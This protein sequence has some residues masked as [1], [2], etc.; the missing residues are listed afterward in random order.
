[1]PEPTESKAV[2]RSCRW[3]RRLLAVYPKA[4]RQEYGAAILQLFRDQ[5]R[6]AWAERRLR[7]LIA[8]WLR[9]LFDLLKTS[10]A[11]HFSNTRRIKSML[12][13]FRP[14]FKPLPLFL[15]ISALV[16]VPVFLTSVVVTYLSPETY[17]GTARIMIN[18]SQANPSSNSHSELWFR[19]E[20]ELIQSPAVLEKVDKKLGLEEIWSKKYNAGAPLSGAVVEALIKSR[21]TILPARNASI[22]EIRAFSDNPEEAAQLANGVAESY[23]D[24]RAK[25]GLR[26][27]E[28]LPISRPVA[29]IDSAVPDN[30]PV[31]PNKPLNFVIGALVGILI[32]SIVATLILG[33]V[34]SLRKNRNPAQC[35]Q[36]G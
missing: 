17:A 20:S 18:S 36:N 9:A 24:Y 33:I 14:T 6:D 5:C 8:F 25:E 12:T 7:G 11:E 32:G 2:E 19:T 23:R 4:H 29:I 34:A 15:L 22:M 35:P 28:A 16:F 3:F 30:V 10:I 27:G 1:M 26:S 21:L 31:R 13:L